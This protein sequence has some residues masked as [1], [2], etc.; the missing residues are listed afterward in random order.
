MKY[1]K[2]FEQ[3]NE[4]FPEEWQENSIEYKHLKKLLTDVVEELNMIGLNKSKLLDL[5]LRKTEDTHIEYVLDGPLNQP[6]PRLIVQFNDNDSREEWLSL[7]NLQKGSSGL[8]AVTASTSSTS[9]KDLDKQH[10]D[11]ME[12]IFTDGTDPSNKEIHIPLNADAKFLGALTAAFDKLEALQMVEKKKFATQVET[13][14]NAITGV[15]GP[16]AV[17]HSTF[18][19]HKKKT[20]D[21]YAWREIFTLWVESAIYEGITESS[22]GERDVESAEIR[23]NAFAAEVVKRGLGDSRT[24]KSKRSRQALDQ[25]LELNMALLEIKKF[26]TANLEAARKILKKHMKMTALPTDSFYSFAGVEGSALQSATSSKNSNFGWTFYTISLPRVLL[27]RLTE[28]LIP[29]IPSIDDYNCLICQEIAFKPI[30]LNCTHIF[31]VRCLVKMQKRGQSD[32]PLC[33]APV[34][35]SANRNNLDQA[36][37]GFME[38]YFPKE[39]RAKAKANDKEAQ[40]EHMEENGIEDVNWFTLTLKWL[41]VRIRSAEGTFRF[42]LSGDDSIELLGDRIIESAPTLDKHTLSLSNEPRG[43]ETQLSSLSKRKL[44]DLG[45][46]HGDLLFA[47]SAKVPE[48]AQS[49]STASGT[50]SSLPARPWQLVKDHP[51]DAHWFRQSGKIPR[52][53]SS[54][55][56]EGNLNTLPIEPYDKE[57]Q[58]QQ[59]IKHLSFH[60]YLRKLKDS[61]PPTSFV[62]Q[63]PPLEE[64]DFK[65]KQ[66]VPNAI[67]LQVQEY[68]MLDHVEF[69][70]PGLVEGLLN[71]WRASGLQRFGILLGRYA[72]YEAVPM[73]IKAVVEAVHEIPQEGEVDGMTLG[74]PWEDQERVVELAQNAGLEV[75]GMIYSDLSQPPG[76][77]SPLFKRHKDSF[78][79]SSLELCF[80]GHLQN[81]HKLQTTQSKSGRFNSRFI[82][83]VLSGTQNGGIDISAFQISDQGMALIDADIVE[84]SVEPSTLRMKESKPG[85]YI[86]DV[87]YRYKNEYGIDVKKN[88]KPCFPVEYLLVNLTHGFPNQSN[89]VFKSSVFPIENR[90]GFQDQS[91]SKLISTFLPVVSE[92]NG[93]GF[94]NSDD[95]DLE[96]VT[97]EKKEALCDILN[98]WHLIAFLEPSGMFSADESRLALK[99]GINRDERDL[100]KLLKSSSWLNL[101]AIAREQASTQ[102]ANAQSLNEAE[103]IP[104]DVL[105]ASEQTARQ[106]R[107]QREQ[108]QREVD[109]S[110]SDRE[111]IENL[112]SFGGFDFEQAKQCYLACEKNTEM[113]AN[114]LF[115]SM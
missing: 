82:T 75:L 21:L 51:I 85:K 25:F 37:V 24:M 109:V 108:E 93:L 83:C 6:Q 53:T 23:L 16:S 59:N 62:A 69:S 19:L 32:C 77:Q 63:L 89:P 74:L 98:D 100:E 91:V 65:F 8:D 110:P 27:A 94:H 54:S 111:A 10:Q 49:S 47:S 11:N 28:T 71:F 15:T 72:P 99:V 35:M 26:Y 17:N 36:L 96:S 34:V 107:E 5:L 95:V 73:G 52:Q 44:S 1:G 55:S 102:A 12:E 105:A 38:L 68:R 64:L 78:F 81:Q 39:V 42:D 3:L 14:C 101:M 114:L 103:D 46:K 115:E 56:R 92:S 50:T 79:L 30:R 67:T 29:I 13:L 97:N 90:Q 58:A 33:R 22:R 84:P 7:Y 86:P 70:S 106:E 40:K 87:F 43:G 66:W 9:N 113:A 20:N 41:I 104:H 48:P 4:E 57:Y 45:I 61:N 112:C 31:C 88:A 60:A 18:G 80:A 76:T 2:Q